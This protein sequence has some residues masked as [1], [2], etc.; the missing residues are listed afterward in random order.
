MKAPYNILIEPYPD[1]C[2]L[3]LFGLHFFT[4]LIV[5]PEAC[6]PGV[7]SLFNT[8]CRGGIEAILWGILKCESTAVGS[9]AQQE[10]DLK[11]RVKNIF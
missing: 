10:L 5:A 11:R 1:K 8:I 4:K 9:N 2:P 3:C 7:R 6:L